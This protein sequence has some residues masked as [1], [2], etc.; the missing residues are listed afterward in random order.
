VATT[1]TE[2]A[3]RARAV[4]AWGAVGGL[5]MA[6]GPVLGGLLVGGLG[7][8]SVFWINVPIG[9]LAVLGGVYLLP[10]TRER[11]RAGGRDLPGALLLA[12]AST[13]LLL[14]LSGVSGLP[15]PRWAAF[16]LLAVAALTSVGFVV[17]L[18]CA[19]TPLIDLALLRHRNVAAGLVGALG[20]YLV[21]FGPLVL[22]PVTFDDAGRSQLHAGFVLTAL[23]AGFALAATVADRLLPG[24]WTSRARATLGASL[25]VLALAGLLAAPPAT[26]WL[27]VPLGLLGVA[28]G[29]FT[30]ANNT[31][32]MAAVPGPAA[33]TGGGLVNMA[34]GLGT[35]LGVAGVALARSGGAGRHRP[36]DGATLTVLVLAATSLVTVCSAWAQRGLS[37]ERAVSPR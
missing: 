10:R 20:G 27:I 35:A 17:R 19:A 2:P 12:T 5:S 1:F 3:A 13:S 37:A 28:L 25:S 24:G 31:L 4:G 30:P 9:V 11:S 32:I 15:L 6:G 26:D 36:L 29:L 23:P 7:W 18:R 34:R 33:A 14:G 22:V 16:G 8:R 21:L